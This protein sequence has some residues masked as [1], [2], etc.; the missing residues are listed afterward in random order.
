MKTVTL[1]G[2]D[3]S[4][5]LTRTTLFSIRGFRVALHR[6]HR[7]DQ[8]E[9]LHDHPWSFWT[10]ILRGGYF[11]ETP[12]WS[13]GVGYPGDDTVPGVCR[14]CDTGTYRYVDQARGELYHYPAAA[15]FVACAHVPSARRT[16]W[17]PP[18]SLLRRVAPHPHRVVLPPG[19]LATTL[20][21]TT[22]PF[23]PWGFLTR[24]GWV[25]WRAYHAQAGHPCGD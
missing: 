6:F 14:L 20:I 9:D 15:G 16:T 10:F 21:V 11:E 5:Y 3:G 23:R 8:D 18:G 24:C 1:H 4:P 13:A 19:C 17:H 22:P 2:T 25:P 7:G 12:D